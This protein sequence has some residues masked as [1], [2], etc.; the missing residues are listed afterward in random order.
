MWDTLHL[1]NMIS[2][3]N[4]VQ[5]N[6]GWKSKWRTIKRIEKKSKRKKMKMVMSRMMNNKK[7]KKKNYLMKRIKLNN[8][9]SYKEKIR[10]KRVNR[11][12]LMK[13]NISK[14]IMKIT[15]ATSMMK[16]YKNWSEILVIISILVNK[17]LMSM[18]NLVHHH[19]KSK[20]LKA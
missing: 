16:S 9:M 3:S 20:D 19:H 17:F 10:N 4:I 8:S 5:N 6:K 7:Y 13:F 18:I 2:W 14:A 12:Y 1:R 11:L 15:K